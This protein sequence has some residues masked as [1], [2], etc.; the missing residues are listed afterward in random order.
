[1]RSHYAR[2]PQD[3][4][5]NIPLFDDPEGILLV[6]TRKAE[7]TEF[8]PVCKYILVDDIDPSAHGAID[9]DYDAQYPDLVT[10]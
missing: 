9:A 6:P 7:L 10:K 4:D 3:D 8:C 2:V 5:G 1:M